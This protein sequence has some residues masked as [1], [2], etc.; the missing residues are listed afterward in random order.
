MRIY[1]IGYMGSGKSTLGRQLASRLNLSFLDMDQAIEGKYLKTIPEIFRDEGEMNFRE[2]EQACLRKIS[3]IENVV[4]ATGGGVP[5]FFNNMEVMNS[6]GC[7]VFLDV[8]PEE[9]AGRLMQAN[10]IRP[11]LQKRTKEELVQTIGEMIQKRRPFYEKARYIVKGNM[12]TPDDVINKI[13]G[14]CG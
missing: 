2:K 6:T 7:C 1:L 3:A 10:G 4:I 12:I 9:L 11:L 14:N 13:G 8:E 5:C